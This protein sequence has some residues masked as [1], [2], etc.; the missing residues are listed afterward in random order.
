VHA[1][2]SGRV[3]DAFSEIAERVG[4]TSQPGASGDILPLVRRWLDNEANGRWLLIVDNIDDEI[5][6]ELNNGQSVERL[7]AVAAERP[8]SGPHH[9]A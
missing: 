4:L 2:N 9:V 7:T 8:W 3:E 5:T 1:N 6:I